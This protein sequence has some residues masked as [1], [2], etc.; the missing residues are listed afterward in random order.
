MKYN[1]LRKEHLNLRGSY[2]FS[3]ETLLCAMF[4][5]TDHLHYKVNATYI[6]T[7]HLH[8]KVNAMYIGTDHLNFKEQFYCRIRSFFFQVIL[9]HKS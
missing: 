8:Y 9:P 3:K 6:G 5:G 1:V 7:N 4:I 2:V